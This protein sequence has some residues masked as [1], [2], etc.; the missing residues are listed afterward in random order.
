MRV[1]P[2]QGEVRSQ[3]PANPRAGNTRQNE[4]GQHLLPISRHF[5][6][7]L[8]SPRGDGGRSHQIQGL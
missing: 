3:C 4:V 7:F 1:T 5:R 8:L 2:V 6:Q